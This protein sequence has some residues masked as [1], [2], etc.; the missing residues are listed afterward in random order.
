MVQLAIIQNLL[1]DAVRHLPHRLPPAVDCHLMQIV[2]K[3]CALVYAKQRQAG[4]E[5]WVPSEGEQQ[6]SGAGSEI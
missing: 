4:Q 5:W 2:T 3:V 6:G 1:P